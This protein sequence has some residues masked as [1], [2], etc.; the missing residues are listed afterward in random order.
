MK[1]EKPIIRYGVLPSR[2]GCIVAAASAKGVCALKLPTQEQL[3]CALAE[4]R[5]HFPHADLVEDHLALQPILN[6]ALAILEGRHSDVRLIFDVKGT[7]FQKTVWRY[8]QTI[9]PG[10]TRSYREVARAIGRPRAVRAVAQACARNPIAL[11]VPCHR[12][13][14]SDGKLGGYRWGL[15]QK[16]RLLDAE[17]NHPTARSNDRPTNP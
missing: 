12:V 5:R 3:S 1:R 10:T 14:R 13:I 2:F 7:P 9:P 4:L 15:A 8:L 17:R 6:H 11:F 16:E